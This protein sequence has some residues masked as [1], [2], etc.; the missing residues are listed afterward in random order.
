MVVTKNEQK[1]KSAFT[2]IV[3]QSN[4]KRVLKKRKPALQ[5]LDRNVECWRMG[6]WTKDMKKGQ[7][8]KTTLW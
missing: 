5:F 7:W 8:G 3:L 6:I 1:S 4:I 2:L